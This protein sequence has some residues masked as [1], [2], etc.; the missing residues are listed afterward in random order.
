MMSCRS[1]ILI[2]V[3]GVM[4]V[5]AQSRSG[6]C[7]YPNKTT[8]KKRFDDGTTR[9]CRLCP[10]G[11][12][13]VEP[14]SKQRN[15]KCAWCP[16]GT[17]LAESNKCRTCRHCDRCE[18]N[19]LMTIRNCTATRPS[20]CGCLPDWK[21]VSP[22]VCNIELPKCPK[23]KFRQGSKCISHSM[24]KK[25]HGVV[26]RGTP[27][28]DTVCERCLNGTFSRRSSSK[29]RCQPQPLCVGP[30]KIPGTNKRKAVCS[31]YAN[32]KGLASSTIAPSN[33]TW[34][35]TQGSIPDHPRLWPPMEI[36]V[37]K[38]PSSSVAQE[39][40]TELQS[41]ISTTDTLAQT[42]PKN[43]ST[44]TTS[45]LG[46]TTGISQKASLTITSDK[47]NNTLP[48]LA[49][50]TSSG[51]KGKFTATPHS[52]DKSYLHDQAI[53]KIVSTVCFTF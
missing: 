41:I 51:E 42:V 33:A 22:G 48:K 32:E 2:C 40:I 12:H 49:S 50:T 4:V 27:Y 3:L 10:S 13:V 7:L 34:N 35:E 53:I 9:R 45:T 31:Q 19:G 23:R 8:F 26:E 46:S 6:G 1:A 21:M 38:Q 25:G 18:G 24:C 14:C 52:V 15:T 47:N 30:P 11:Q 28:T 43:D 39:N 29:A 16:F 20:I 37:T 36:N 17:Y 44:T 5:Y